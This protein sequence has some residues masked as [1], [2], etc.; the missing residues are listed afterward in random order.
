[1]LSVSALIPA[2]N[3]ERYVGDAIE[4][5][6]R[7]DRP[8]DEIVVVDDG[9]TDETAKVATAFARVRLVRLA[10]PRGTAGARNAAIAASHCDVI[11]WLDS[12]DLWL[13]D[14]TAT[15]VALLERYPATVVAFTNAEYFGDRSG[16]WPR[17]D[18]P[19]DEPFDALS[20]AFQRTISTMSPAVT[21]RAAVLAVGGFDESLPSSVDFDLFLRLSLVGPFVSTPRTTTRYRWH[22]DQ[23]SA[24]PY[25]QLESMYASRIKLLQSLDASNRQRITTELR[26]RLVG[27]VHADLWEVWH[28]KDSAGLKGVIALARKIST[29]A[30]IAPPFTASGLRNLREYSQARGEIQGRDLR[31]SSVPSLFGRPRWLYRNAVVAEM[32]YRWARL[33][34]PPEVWLEHLIDAANSW[35]R[36]R[37]ARG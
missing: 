35:G 13:P 15:A 4:S 7:Q 22:G 16:P 26:T 24:V 8:V 28:Q 2:R 18:V 25:K 20:V 32:R 1:M 10:A 36:T 27:C 23:I 6:L 12:D 19:E 34:K 11:A 29:D 3:R 9:S 14:H 30:G 31:S 17:P 33:T 21:R 5:V 37:G